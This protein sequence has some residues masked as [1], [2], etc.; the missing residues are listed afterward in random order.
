LTDEL[1]T[2]TTLDV[3]AA[4]PPSAG[5]WPTAPPARRTSATATVRS[6]TAPDTARRSPRPS[7]NPPRRLRSA[8]SRSGCTSAHRA[9]RFVRPDC[10][11]PTLSSSQATRGAGF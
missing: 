1:R 11:A 6:C 4:G 7:W 3:M 8:N 9:R 5:P 10:R 2:D